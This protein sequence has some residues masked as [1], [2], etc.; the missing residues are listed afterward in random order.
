MSRSQCNFLRTFIFFVWRI[1]DFDLKFNF[2][3]SYTYCESFD[4]KSPFVNFRG[5]YYK[6][7]QDYH[8]PTRCKNNLLLMINISTYFML[9][10]EILR[11]F[12]L[13][14]YVWI[15]VP[16]INFAFINFTSTKFIKLFTC[17]YWW[18]S[19]LYQ[20]KIEYTRD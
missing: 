18:P 11:L 5:K 19:F 4:V 10:C 7:R 3:Y 1:W 9:H 17:W 13:S 2:H 15:N 14:T 8:I 20:K 6:P 12:L 16:I